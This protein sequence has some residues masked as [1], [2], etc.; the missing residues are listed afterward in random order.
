MAVKNESAVLEKNGNE[1][2]FK[3]AGIN[4]LHWHKIYGDDGQDLTLQA[5]EKL[6]GPDAKTEKIVENIKNMRFLHE[7]LVQLDMLSCP[8]HRYYY[9]TD[10]MI[11]EEL[12]EAEGE[13]TRGQVV[14]RL[15]ERLFELYKDPNL[16]H[17][18]EELA[19]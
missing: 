8:Y 18:P 14:K 17:K 5:I 15:E 16:D 13:G 2:F 4:H 12:E 6:Y 19:K 7:Q 3:F 9:M 1:L 11:Q 10:A